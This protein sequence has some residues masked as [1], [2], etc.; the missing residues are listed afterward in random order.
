MSKDVIKR[1]DSKVFGVSQKKCQLAR[2]ANSPVDY[3]MSQ[4]SHPTINIKTL[5]YIKLLL[6]NEFQ[7]DRHNFYNGDNFT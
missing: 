7:L 2:A 4:A 6:V 1:V 5:V 3:V